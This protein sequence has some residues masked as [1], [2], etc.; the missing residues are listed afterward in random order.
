MKAKFEQSADT[1]DG[2]PFMLNDFG[3]RGVSSAESA[4]LG[5]MAH[6]L[7]FMGTDNLLAVHAAFEMYNAEE[8]P[9]FSVPASE[10]S[11]MTTWGKESEADAFAN[12]IET[13][14]KSGDYPIVSVVSD[15]YDYY[16]AVTELWCGKFKEDIIA[17][18]E[19]GSKLVIRPDSGDPETIVRWTLKELGKAFGYTVNSKGYKVLPPYIGIIQGDGVNRQSI[20][21]IMDGIMDDGWSVENVVFGM[22]GGLLQ[23]VD[24]DTMKFAMKCSAAKVDGEWIDV[25]KDPVTD[26]GKKS[27]RGRLRVNELTDGSY[28]CDMLHNPPHDR[29]FN[30]GVMEVVFHNGQIIRHENFDD[31]KKRI[32]KSL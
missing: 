20:G 10:H 13:F 30:T 18:G 19:V 16:K 25:Y 23:Q 14:G 26:H 31:I 8:M 24:R 5:G 15:S 22:G 27:K 3:R 7:S 6:L 21:Q 11:T 29:V 2:L 1:L 17:M 12:M 28:E 32:D 4:R 9:G